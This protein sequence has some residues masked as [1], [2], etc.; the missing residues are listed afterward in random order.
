MEWQLIFNILIPILG[1]LCMVIYTN[2]D[3]KVKDLKIDMEKQIEAKT[4]EL[5]N[6]YHDLKASH[7]KLTSHMFELSSHLPT[8]YVSKDELR[9]MIDKLFEKLDR[10]S[11]QLASKQD[12]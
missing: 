9:H 1:V 11:E 10:I 2:M 8:N 12:R 5:S 4:A 7:E 3:N 6:R